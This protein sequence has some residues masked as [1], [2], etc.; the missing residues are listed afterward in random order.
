MEDIKLIIIMKH[1]FEFFFGQWG[2]LAGLGLSKI[3]IRI[4]I[5]GELIVP[6]NRCK[7]KDS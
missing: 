3:N 7:A 5:D 1:F 2:G 4:A 6:Q